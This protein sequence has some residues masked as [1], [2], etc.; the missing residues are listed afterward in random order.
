MQKYRSCRYCATGSLLSPVTPMAWKNSTAGAC[1]LPKVKNRIA[2]HPQCT[3]ISMIPASAA[4]MTA[5]P[6]VPKSH[7]FCLSFPVM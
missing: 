1:L 4:E 3:K 5:I 2:L 7:F 6:T